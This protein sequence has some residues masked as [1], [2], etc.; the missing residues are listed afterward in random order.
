MSAPTFGPGTFG[1]RSV[2]VTITHLL[3]ARSVTRTLVP[4]RKAVT[5]TELSA[6]GEDIDDILKAEPRI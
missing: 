5:E 6:I 1:P 4:I 2:M 3:L